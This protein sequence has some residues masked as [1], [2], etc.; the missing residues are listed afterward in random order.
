V[1][2]TP[3]FHSYAT[4]GSDYFG[5]AISA[6]AAYRVLEAQLNDA[7]PERFPEPLKR[8]RVRLDVSNP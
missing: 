7:Y 1:I 2:P 8:L 4:V 5:D 3:I 6:L